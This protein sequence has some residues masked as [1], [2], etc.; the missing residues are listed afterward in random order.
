MEPFDNRLCD[1]KL[2][3]ANERL[4][5]ETGDCWKQ[6][7]SEVKQRGNHARFF[8]VLIECQLEALRKYLEEVDKVVRD[9]RRLDG[10]AVTS[11][12]IRKVLVPRVFGVIAARKGA[13]Q[14]ELE[15]RI[16]R[17]GEQSTTAQHY[18]IQKVSHLQ[19]ELA[20][21]YEVEAIELGKR[22]AADFASGVSAPTAGISMREDA[23]GG[24]RMDRRPGP[25]ADLWRD[26][27][28]K[29]RAL[30]GEEQGR[31]VPVTKGR[32]LQGMDLL[33]AYG[34]LRRHPEGW[35]RGKPEQG[36]ISLLH[37][38][39]HGV[40]QLSDGVSEN[41]QARFRT[42]AAR[43][44]VALGSSKDASPEDFWLH[45]LYLDLRENNSE[46]LFAASE[47]GG[48]IVSVCVAS[49]TFCSQLERQAFEQSE[50]SNPPG[51][52]ASVQTQM[53]R[54]LPSFRTATNHRNHRP[55]LGRKSRSP[56]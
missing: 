12:F 20:S 36:Q 1:L 34:N 10:H 33:R 24:K 52:R 42:L 39:P 48:M 32:V 4:H 56:F 37:T 35:E 22:R 5:A 51:R 19:S 55:C 30:A 43:A 13:I 14:H 3:L 15:L 44:G 53:R 9:V 40:W 11:E 26:F 29:F 25:K 18:L 49:A 54:N 38:P 16:L 47:E 17:T 23:S 28:E 41:L 6:A 27:H 31:A 46:L 21:R 2:R 7:G 8:P 50:P 45:Q